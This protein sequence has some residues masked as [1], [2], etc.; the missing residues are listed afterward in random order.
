MNLLISDLVDGDSR[1]MIY[2]DLR[3][4]CPKPAPFLEFDADPYAAVVDGRLVW[5]WDAYTTADRYP[6]S[7]PVDLDVD[8]DAAE[9]CA[10]PSQERGRG[11]GRTTSGTR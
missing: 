5:I 3:S 4:G 10:L 1:I 11:C 8:R 7:E 2:R 6:Y 9:S